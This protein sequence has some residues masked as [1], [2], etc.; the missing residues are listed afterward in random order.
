MARCPNIAALAFLAV[1]IASCTTTQSM[2]EGPALADSNVTQKQKV[3]P[4]K[5]EPV[6]KTEKQENKVTGA[7]VAE[8]LFGVLLIALVGG[9]G[10]T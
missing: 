7:D 5:N 4:T 10:G 9:G 6:A 2:N 1:F 3:E 8:F